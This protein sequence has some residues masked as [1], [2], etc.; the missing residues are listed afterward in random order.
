[1]C[2]ILGGVAIFLSPSIVYL[3]GFLMLLKLI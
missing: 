1:M 3:V 2:E